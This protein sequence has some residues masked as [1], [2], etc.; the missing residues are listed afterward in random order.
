MMENLTALVNGIELTAYQKA[1][2]K[3]EYL[4][5]LESIKFAISIRDLWGVMDFIKSND[6]KSFDGD[7]L[8]ALQ[9]MEDNFNK[10]ID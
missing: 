8:V 3:K 9:K 7:E 5:M 2:A 10:I 4:Q 6:E 1:L